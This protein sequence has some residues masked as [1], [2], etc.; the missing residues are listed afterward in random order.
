MPEPTLP[1]PTLLVFPINVDSAIPI[2]RTAKMLGFRIIGASSVLPHSQLPELDT[3]IHLPFITEST[4]NRSFATAL[5]QH[6]VTY[7]LAPHHGVWSH[8]ETLSQTFPFILCGEH[9]FEQ[10]WNNFQASREWG[11]NMHRD[12]FA[13]LVAPAGSQAA[14]PLSMAE[15][16][17]IHRGFLRI[18]GESDVE[19]LEALCAIARLVPPGDV[20]EIG[21]LYGRSAYALGRLA[22]AHGIGSTLCID[23]WRTDALIDQGHQAS[24]INQGIRRIDLERVFQEFLSTAA[25]VPGMSY[26]RK[27]S[28]EA[29][30]DYVA[31]G[32]CG[33]LRAPELPDVSIRGRIS[34]LHIDGNH[35][36]DEVLRDIQTWTPL[37][38]E[39]G[40]LLLD[41]YVWAFGD[42]PKIAGDKLLATSGFD[43][44]FTCSD[45]LFLR[46]AESGEN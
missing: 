26:I 39:G 22:H 4:F 35:R 13:S 40:W 1:P 23:P 19:K 45:T 41:D 18:P 17:S 2:T 32:A 43:L 12:V 27:P 25:E 30:E 24:I 29:L 14:W 44:S 37:L 34:L 46:K 3:C 21:S 7:V 33:S 15:Y 28:C 42:G 38:A 6:R 11:V 10:N 5:R 36:Y 31:A 20:V 16:A 9:P 8:L